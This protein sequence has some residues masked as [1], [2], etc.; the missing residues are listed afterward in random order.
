MEAHSLFNKECYNIW[1]L[2]WNNEYRYKSYPFHK[3]L[4]KMNHRSACKNKTVK[5][6]EG[7]TGENL[8]DLGFVDEI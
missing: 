2:L 7:N 5:L 3:N 6:L 4:L 8:G 1:V